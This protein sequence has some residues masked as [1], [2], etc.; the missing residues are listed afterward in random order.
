M[1]VKRSP[2]LFS[3]AMRLL[4]VCISVL[5]A[6]LALTASAGEP[7]SYR[8]GVKQFT[9][10]MTRKHGFAKT[11]IATLMGQAMYSQDVINAM[12]RP[13]EA[14][15]WYKYRRIFLTEKRIQGGAAFWRE[16]RELLESAQS[17]YGVPPQMVTAI[18][19]VESN[20]G[21]NRG[22]HRV[23]DALST[24]GFSYPKRADFF[25]KELEQFLLLTREESV[26]ALKVTGS[27][28]GAVGMPQFIP[29]SYRAYAVD[30]DK[31][32]RRDLWE[33]SADAIGSVGSYFQR[34]GWTRGE[35]VAVEAKV[36]VRV[37]KGVPV[38]GK[39]PKKPGT[40]WSRL[41]AAGVTT[42]DPL[43][44]STRVTLIRLDAPEPE[45]WL[46]MK[47]FYAITR[48]NH[49]NLYAM[50]VYQLSREIQAAYAKGDE[51]GGKKRTDRDRT[52]GFGE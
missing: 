14:K 42:I 52:V 29:S 19:G 24:L 20:Y 33:S 43:P 37:P 27:Y 39:K 13:Y 3:K 12:R 23:I 18:I 46:G 38:A 16:N 41:Q 11:E 9:T 26:D 31:D 22:K 1:R 6:L 51:K 40:S 21:A 47:N 8:S 49:S 34:H 2:E 17:V 45:Y 7:A 5:A 44:S 35:P 30:F 25:R 4:G 36:P 15:P 48:Y 50:A 32:G 10:D 28:A